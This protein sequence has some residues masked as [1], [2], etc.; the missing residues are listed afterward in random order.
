MPKK[1]GKKAILFCTYRIWKG[2]T[3]KILEKQLASKGYESILSVSKKGM[4]PDE[5]ADF[6]E[7]VGE[8][9]KVLEKQ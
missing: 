7:V 5:E 3:F 4:K 9:R 8:V 2:S 1:E 6:S